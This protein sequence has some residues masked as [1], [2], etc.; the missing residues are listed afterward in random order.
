ML[1]LRRFHHNTQLN[2][3]P[4][5]WKVKG[6][7]RRQLVR[8]AKLNS[9]NYSNQKETEQPPR[10]AACLQPKCSPWTQ[11]CLTIQSMQL[12]I[13]WFQFQICFKSR[14]AKVQINWISWAPLFK[15]EAGM[16]AS[17][18]YRQ[19]SGAKVI[20]IW[21]SWIVKPRKLMQPRWPR[22]DSSSC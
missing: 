18:F 19:L 20:V 6:I 12:K 16:E 21:T 13:K 4:P 9:K 11:R 15:L 22:Q 1:T 17:S 7:F 8:L 14:Q 10:W 5:S 3:R 2:S